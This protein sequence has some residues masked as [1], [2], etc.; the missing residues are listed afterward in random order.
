[1]AT[2]TLQI[3]REVSVAYASVVD[4]LQKAGHFAQL[5][6]QF[7]R[8]PSDA[9]LPTPTALFHLGG[10][11]V[12][13]AVRES[14]SQRG[15][16]QAV[17]SMIS[18]FEY[19]LLQLLFLRRLTERFVRLAVIP[20]N[21][22]LQIRRSVG[23]EIRARPTALLRKIIQAPSAEAIAGSEWLD[24]IYRVRVCVVHRDGHGDLEDVDD[25]QSLTV[26]W[27]KADL[28]AG[29][30]LITEFPFIAHDGEN[31]NIR[32]S[33]TTRIWKLGERIELESEDCRS[34][35]F[36]LYL[37]ATWIQK[38]FFGEVSPMIKGIKPAAP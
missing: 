23:G 7:G 11:E 19:F 22:M 14:F 3:D 21:D 35:S 38:E 37:L 8:L 20:A 13:N 34:M 1:M 6:D 31:I 25:P 29:E 12:T 16:A 28:Y 2:Q 30:R 33:D 18:S 27:R 9:A 15:A 32:F 17:V 5:C 26:T 36:A 4:S 10:P 24:G